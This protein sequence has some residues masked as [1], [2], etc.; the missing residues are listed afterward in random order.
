MFLFVFWLYYKYLG[1]VSFVWLFSYVRGSLSADSAACRCIY[2]VFLVLPHSQFLS[3]L[4]VIFHLFIGLLFWELK[5]VYIYVFTNIWTYIYMYIHT[6]IYM[7]IYMYIRVYLYR[8]MYIWIYIH[9]HIYFIYIFISTYVYLYV[10][11]HTYLF[12]CSHIYVFY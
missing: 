1:V 6:Y 4:Y 8:Y 7:F 10:Y 3:F 12:I 11:I 9:I 2:C 5:I